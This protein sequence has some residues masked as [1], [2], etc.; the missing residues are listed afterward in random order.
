MDGCFARA[1]IIADYLREKGYKVNYAYVNHP[2][3]PNSDKRF[4]YHIAA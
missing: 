4:K 3:M 1:C 2:K